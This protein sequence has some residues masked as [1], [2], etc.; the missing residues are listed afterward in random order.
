MWGGTAAAGPATSLLGGAA[1]LRDRDHVDVEQ[2]AD[3]CRNSQ[4]GGPGLLGYDECVSGALLGR[5]RHPPQQ[6]PVCGVDVQAIK[7]RAAIAPDSIP[8]TAHPG[9]PSRCAKRKI[10][11]E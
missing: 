7:T 4:R 8:S 5:V 2:L 1:V 11:K 3:A 6:L 10:A 9:S